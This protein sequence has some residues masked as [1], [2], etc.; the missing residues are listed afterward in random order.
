MGKSKKRRYQAKAGGARGLA[1]G[2][3]K[4]AG[5]SALATIAGGGAWGCGSTATLRL[6]LS[7]GPMPPVEHSGQPKAFESVG[8]DSSVDL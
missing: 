7:A 2:Q 1:A 8:S 6:E 5:M 3:V 4:R